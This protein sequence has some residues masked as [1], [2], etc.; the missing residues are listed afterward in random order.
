[1]WK[2]SPGKCGPRLEDL[3][4]TKQE[5]QGDTTPLTKF[6]KKARFPKLW[7]SMPGHV[8][9]VR[10]ATKESAIPVIAMRTVSQRVGCIN[11]WK[12]DQRIPWITHV[13]LPNASSWRGST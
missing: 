8:L 2:N 5:P 4:Q 11:K 9:F 12:A 7:P 13:A 3:R 1:M 6:R 10:C